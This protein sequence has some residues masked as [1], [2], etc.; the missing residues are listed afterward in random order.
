MG[1]ILSILMPRPTSP[2][3]PS[4]P[5]ILICGGGVVGLALAQGC[6]EAGIPYT[7]FERDDTSSSRAQGWALT[8]HWCLDALERTIGPERAS[9]LET[10]V[11]DSSL[12]E[13]EGNFLFLNAATSKA[14]YRIPP[15]KRRLR[16]HRQKLRGILASGLNIEYGKSAESFMDL[17]DGRIKVSFSD[18][19]SANGSLLVGAD[20]NNSAIRSQLCKEAS[21]NKL[22][23]NLIGVVRHFTPDQA[24]AVRAIDPLLFQALHPDTGNYLWFSI[25]ECIPEPTGETSYNA[26]VIISWLIHDEAQDAIPSTSRERIRLMKARAEGFA[27]PLKSIVMDIPDDEPFTTPLRLGDYVPDVENKWDNLGGKVTLA[28]D[29]AH[30]M[31]MYRG[32]GA[33][34]GILDAALFV[35]AMKRVVNGEITQEEAVGAYEEEMCRRTKDAVLKS[36]RA[37]LDAH[38]WEKVTDESP[39]IGARIPP[40]TA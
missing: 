34:H 7:L 24:K 3:P 1:G 27:E 8:L 39:C 37:A 14:K 2:T 35:D 22:P 15:S 31:T 13:D 33:N 29:A 11:V 23:V 36:R 16:L 5:H 20:G 21:L 19:T 18:G 40:A 12:G 32:E 4:E 9:K 38:V 26:L 28:G 25:Q 30:A 17:P 6:R 10:A